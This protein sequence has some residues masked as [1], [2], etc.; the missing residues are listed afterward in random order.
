MMRLKFV[1]WGLIFLL[2]WPVPA[3][4]EPAFKQKPQD[5]RV[6][7]EVEGYKLAKYEPVEGTYLGA[8]VYQDTL[9]KGDMKEFNRLT[10]KKHASFF[11]YVGYGQ[12]FP[13]W[14]IDQLKEVGAAAHIA[15]EP[16]KGLDQVKDDE[17]LRGF[18]RKLKEAGIPVFLRFASEM[19]GDWTAYSGDPK[20]YIE[21]WRLVH[22]VM[23][24]EAP[25]VMMVWTVFTFPQS[26]IIKYYPGDEYVDWVGVNIYNV[27]YHNNNIKHKASHEDPLE[28]LD[29]VYDTF[30][31][32]KPIQISEYGATHY[33]VTDGKYYE[34]FAIQKITRMYNGIKTRYPRVK[35]IFY[36]NV[37]NLAN[38]PEGRRINNYAITDNKR[39]LGTYSELI[40][41]PHFL[42]DIGPNLEG[43]TD[44]ELMH[45]RDGVHIVKGKIFVSS[46]V[47]KEYMKAS[48]NW[49]SKKKQITIKKGERSAVLNVV[50]YANVLRGAKGAFTLKG[51]S[52]LPLREAADALGY[53][54]M[55]DNS[56]K[57]IKVVL[58]D[59]T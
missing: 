55:W 47:L 6:L 28:L 38:A 10:G 16:N 30:S 31:M 23:E 49:D 35:S 57:L 50:S 25:N 2:A 29:Y 41:D 21:K 17:Y 36:F 20:K 39:I 46:R 27:V 42:S 15:W 4:A 54:V 13:Q 45:V 59:R 18:A 1:I 43:R 34:D 12:K 48:V 26:T 22:D 32:R 7:I 33:T 58:A 44:R 40:E 19:N 14:W 8:Y 37:N 11:L 5:I 52:Y 24:Q 9:I 51:T 56:E 53:R 3:K